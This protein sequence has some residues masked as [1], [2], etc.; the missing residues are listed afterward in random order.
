M[1]DAQPL[2]GII[3]L[4]GYMLTIGYKFKLREAS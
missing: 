1:A 4:K 3:S 2:Y